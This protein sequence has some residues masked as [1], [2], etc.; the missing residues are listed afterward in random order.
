MILYWRQVIKS[1]FKTS[2]WLNCRKTATISTVNRAERSFT[3]RRSTCMLRLD[4]RLV[5][6][7]GL[8]RLQSFAPH[9]AEGGSPKSA[10]IVVLK[11]GLRRMREWVSEECEDL[12]LSVQS[13]GLRRTPRLICSALFGHR[14]RTLRNKENYPSRLPNQCALSRDIQLM[15]QCHAQCLVDREPVEPCKN[16]RNC[17][18][19]VMRKIYQNTNCSRA[20]SLCCTTRAHTI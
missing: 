5:R 14:L 15:T 18:D 1:S 20:S 19:P 12:L 6:R 13:V 2:K 10:E 9:C 3:Y 11:V 8:R 16:C 17:N 4:L 7:V